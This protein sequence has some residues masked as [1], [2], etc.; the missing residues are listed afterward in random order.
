MIAVVVRPENVGF[1]VDVAAPERLPY[2]T[3]GGA[4][5]DDWTQQVAKAESLDFDIFAPGHGR[6]GTH[7]EVAPTR[8]YIEALRAGVL[9][10]LKDGKTV[11]EITA[12]LTMDDYMGWGQYQDWRPMNIQGMADYLTNAGLVE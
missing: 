10:G 5:I 8:E 6:V 1:I 9:Q 11:E 2:Q 3:F 4:N 7:D 12:E